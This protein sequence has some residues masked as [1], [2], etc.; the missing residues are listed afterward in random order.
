M[1]DPIELPNVEHV[2]G[3]WFNGEAAELQ[4][5]AGEKLY[6]LRF[7]LEE[8]FRSEDW[9]ISL[10]RSLAPL[11]AERKDVLSKGSTG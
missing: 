9:F 3:L 5:T 7:P 10:R 8:I 1:P 6:K 2:T 4:F 11:L